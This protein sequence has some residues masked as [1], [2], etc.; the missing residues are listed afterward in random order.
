M[1]EQKLIN[2]PQYMTKQEAESGLQAALFYL[3]SLLKV[4]D[5]LIEA[6]EKIDRWYSILEQ[7]NE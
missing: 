2:V 6:Y 4:E 3:D 5:N 1:D 7:F